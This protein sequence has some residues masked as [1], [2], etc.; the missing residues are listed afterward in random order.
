MSRLLTLD[1]TDVLYGGAEVVFKIAQQSHRGGDFTPTGTKFRANNQWRIESCDFPQ[2]A[3]SA[4]Y[5]FVRG[6]NTQKDNI[7]MGPVSFSVYKKIVDAVTEYNDTFRTNTAS[8]SKAHKIFASANQP[9]SGTVKKIP[10]LVPPPLIRR[11]PAPT[12]KPIGGW[13]K[14]FTL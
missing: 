9:S 5:L 12:S 10:S 8:S 1:V 6:K 2:V 4:N 13:D 7:S 3:L 14:N 11:K